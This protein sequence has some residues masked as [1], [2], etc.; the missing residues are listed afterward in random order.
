[1]SPSSTPG[2]TPT[3]ADCMA[4]R[5]VTFTPEMEIMT[6]MKVLLKKRIS[7]APVVD[8]DGH[9]VGV[10]SKKDCLRVVFTASYH[11]EWGGSVGD[12]MT[13]EVETMDADTDLISAAKKFVEGS[14]RRY[15]VMSGGRL[16]GQVS[17]YDILEA[18]LREW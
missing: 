10:L 3:V 14:Y 9:L 5:L 16:V 11:K 4:R 7:G 12:Y 13:R 18:L 6:A 8:A 15:P 1:M 17:R 2:T